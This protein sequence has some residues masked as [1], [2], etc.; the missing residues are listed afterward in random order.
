MCLPGPQAN[1]AFLPPPHRLP[2]HSARLS[3]APGHRAIEPWRQVRGELGSLTKYSLS[4]EPACLMVGENRWV[5]GERQQ[6]GRGQSGPLRILSPPLPLP[7]L[8][9]GRCL[10]WARAPLPRTKAVERTL[11]SGSFYFVR[12]TTRS[13]AAAPTA[14]PHALFPRSPLAGTGR[15]MTNR[16]PGRPD[17]E[18]INNAAA[19]SFL[20]GKGLAGLLTH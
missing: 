7:H 5:P 1:P 11:G 15:G 3:P 12:I 6:G 20:S 14:L 19:G 16:R 17:P 4:P 10:T 13:A 8:G 18:R 2:K 9:G